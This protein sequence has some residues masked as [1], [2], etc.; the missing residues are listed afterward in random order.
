MREVDV[1]VVG[2]GPAGTAAAITARRAGLTVAVVDKARFPRE[3]ICGD[4][5]TTTCLR[6]LD[7]L[8]LDPRR[9]A[10]WHRVDDVAISSP[11]H[12]QII[13]PLPRNMGEFAVIAERRDLDAALVDLARLVGAGI[14]EG[15]G[16]AAIEQVADGVTVTTDG[17]LELAGR[18]VVAADGMW[19]P[20]RKLLGLETG[21]YLGEWHAFR[22]Y[23]RNV[24]AQPAHRLHVWF[25]PDLL[26]GYVWS[27]PLPQGRSNLGFGI[28]R[29]ASIATRD[30][31]RIWTDI[32]DRP[33]IRSV[34]GPDAEP[35]QPHRAWPI[36][37]RVGRLPL[38]LG[39]T[40]FVG[41]AAAATDPM[42]GEGIAQALF[43][44]MAA[45]RSIARFAAPEQVR[46]HY[47]RHVH[48]ELAI[49]HG[50]ARVLGKVLQ[51]PLGARGAVR[52][53]GLSPWTRRHFARWLFED[54]PRAVVVT[55]SRWRR[56]LFRRPGAYSSAGESQG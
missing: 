55:P 6:L 29:D 50:L 30:M 40:L 38:T 49:D 11:S 14:H 13:F 56:D 47:E 42:T 54:Y 46:R 41:D 36:P 15:H 52:V 48:D 34:I 2:A 4:G 8:G 24:G 31:T 53:A 5:L 25:E 21:R 19:S 16:I 43:T 35:E 26:P 39:R 1:V 33:H 7:E 12:R 20:T 3:K 28:L 10:S 37:A 51:S 18:H 45:A 9:V 17:G 22:Q 44:G 23:F 32:V 27:F